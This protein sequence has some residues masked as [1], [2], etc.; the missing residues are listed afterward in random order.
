MGSQRFT[1]LQK[2]PIRSSSTYQKFTLGKK[3][4]KTH[5]AQ[6]FPIR[7]S[8]T[9]Q[10]LRLGKNSQRFTNSRNSDT[11]LGYLSKVTYKKIPPKIHKAQKFPIRNS[12]TYQKLRFKKSP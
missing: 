12:D 9:Y 8:N 5:K 1:K 6:K 2:F 10:K 4:P 7:S 11:K 3:S